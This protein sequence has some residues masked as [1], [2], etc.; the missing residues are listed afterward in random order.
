MFLMCVKSLFDVHDIIWASS[1]TYS[2]SYP[3][4]DDYLHTYTHL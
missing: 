1:F 2:N 3:W 4:H